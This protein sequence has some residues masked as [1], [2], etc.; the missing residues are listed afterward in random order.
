MAQMREP[1]AIVPADVVKVV[2]SPA[3]AGYWGRSDWS[4]YQL[5]TDIAVTLVRAPR[6][7][8]VTHTRHMVW[9]VTKPVCVQLPRV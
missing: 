5:A 7:K 4:K 2:L 3:S 6:T 8:Y 1:M 9:N